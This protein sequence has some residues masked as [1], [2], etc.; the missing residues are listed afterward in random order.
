MRG[1]LKAA[2]W[3]VLVAGGVL[4]PLY[5]FV[6]DLWRV[7]SDD[8]LLTA[9][10]QPTLGAGDLV[11]VTRH[12]TVTRGNLLRCGDPQAPGRYVVA[13]AVGAPGEHIAIEGD[14][15]SIDRQR[16]PSPRACE[17][18]FRTVVDP[19]TNEEIE[20]SCAI[21]DYGEMTFGTL[22]SPKAPRP[23][24]AAVVAPGQWFL[25]SDDRHVHLD[26]RDYGE[27]DPAGCQHIVFRVVGAKGFLDS[28]TRLAVI[29]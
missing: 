12:T 29:W 22:R 19:A 27:I 23:P 13:R 9:S 5:L 16:M 1:W 17:Q 7:P 11:V 25:V 24:A 14:V 15:V 18:P 21:E 4:V 2:M 3:L 8:P 26:S 20:L 6:F 10:I 28:E